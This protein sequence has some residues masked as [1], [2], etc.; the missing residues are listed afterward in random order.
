MSALKYYPAF[1]SRFRAEIEL[2]VHSF[3]FYM[4]IFSDKVEPGNALQN[5]TYCSTK[6]S[7]CYRRNEAISKTHKT[8]L[9]VLDILVPYLR[10]KLEG[11][12]LGWVVRL[13]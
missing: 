6:Y 13:V 8:G 4:T 2:I 5:I 9:F 1:A 3:Y 10:K 12:S 7:L 11:C